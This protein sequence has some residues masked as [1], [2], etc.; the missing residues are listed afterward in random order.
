MVTVGHRGGAGLQ[1]REALYTCIWKHPMDMAQS[2]PGDDVCR[3]VSLGPLYEVPLTK[4]T[5]TFQQ[6]TG[7]PDHHHDCGRGG[8]G[9]PRHLL[10]HP[11]SSHLRSGAPPI[12]Q[13]HSSELRDWE[14]YFVAAEEPDVYAAQ[15]AEWR[16]L[17]PGPHAVLQG[18]LCGSKFHLRAVCFFFPKAQTWN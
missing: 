18:G 8:G 13:R 16:L 10:H 5:T 6:R 9:S 1:I 4:G 12:H 17:G 15:N 14:Q 11:N 3:P 2:K 7:G